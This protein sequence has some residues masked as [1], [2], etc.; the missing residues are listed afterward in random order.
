MRRKPDT[1]SVSISLPNAPFYPE[2]RHNVGAGPKLNTVGGVEF[3]ES[4]LAKLTLE[5]EGV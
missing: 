2:K 5:A 3:E 4:Y 1:A